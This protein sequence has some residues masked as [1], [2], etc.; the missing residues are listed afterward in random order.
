MKTQLDGA[1]YW[2]ILKNLK[3]GCNNKTPWHSLLSNLRFIICQGSLSTK[4]YVFF[5][6]KTVNTFFEIEIHIS[7]KHFTNIYVV[8]YT[9]IFCIIHITRHEDLH[10]KID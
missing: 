6:T 3:W 7:L 9:K 10:P 5:E 1:S 8:S 4:K 2:Q